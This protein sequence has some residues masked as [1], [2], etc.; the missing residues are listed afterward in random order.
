MIWPW[1]VAAVYL[2]AVCWRLDRD[3]V[4]KKPLTNVLVNEGF[5]VSQRRTFDIGAIVHRHIP[6]KTFE[7]ATLGRVLY[8]GEGLRK[9]LGIESWAAWRLANYPDGSDPHA[10]TRCPPGT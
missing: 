9:A 2:A 3:A 4:R 10:P 5:Q 6:G 1:V 7:N 8:D